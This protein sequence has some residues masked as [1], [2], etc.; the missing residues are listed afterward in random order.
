MRN[1]RFHQPVVVQTG[2]IDR[3]RV[4][5]DTRSAAEILVRHWRWAETPRY[6]RAA[7]ACLDVMKGAKPPHIAR[8]AFIAAAR[9]ARILVD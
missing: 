3:T 4:I 5:A 8:R 2:R 9:E 7:K 6:Q 1:R